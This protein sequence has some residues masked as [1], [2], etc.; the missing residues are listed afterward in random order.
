MKA[1]GYPASDF[2]QRAADVSVDHPQMVQ[3]YRQA[4]QIA[5]RNERGEANTEDLRQAVVHYRSLFDELLETEEVPAE[6]GAHR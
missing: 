5:E 4:H 1:R 2:D 6:V 3:N